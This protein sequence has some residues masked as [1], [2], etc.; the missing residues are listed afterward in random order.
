LS[1]ATYRILR[2]AW[3]AFVA[4]LR[5]EAA[6]LDTNAVIEVD[7]GYSGFSGAGKP[8]LF[9]VATGAVVIAI[10]DIVSQPDLP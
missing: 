4:E 9:M 1:A 6:A 10:P 8:M 3:Q 2:D 7:L 5:R